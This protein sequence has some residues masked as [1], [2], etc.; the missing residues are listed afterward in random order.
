[1]K[2]RSTRIKR[3]ELGRLFENWG[4]VDRFEMGTSYRRLRNRLGPQKATTATAHKLA[5]IVYH[6]LLQHVAYEKARKTPVF[7]PRPSRHPAA[8]RRR[9]YKR[10]PVGVLVFTHLISNV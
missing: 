7:K 9:G 4:L 5:R 10:S 3:G 1:M 2:A 8:G 6:M